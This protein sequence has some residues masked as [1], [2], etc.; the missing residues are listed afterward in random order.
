[1]LLT[2]YTD[3]FMWHCTGINYQCEL[4]GPLKIDN[5]WLYHIYLNMFIP[6]VMTK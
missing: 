4:N 1:M 2:A 6:M 3:L 5:A